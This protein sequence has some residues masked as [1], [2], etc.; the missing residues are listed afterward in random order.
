MSPRPVG[1]RSEFAHPDEGVCRLRPASGPRSWH[2]RR[3]A[4][5]GPAVHAGRHPH[6][7]GDGVALE[8]DLRPWFGE[9]VINAVVHN[10]SRAHDATAHLSDEL[11]G[12]AI[13]RGMDGP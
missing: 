11:T 10:G 4:A 7:T 13:A 3:T 8:K 6:R 1:R 12:I 2:T 5:R 9:A